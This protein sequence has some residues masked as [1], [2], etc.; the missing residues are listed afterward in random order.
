MGTICVRS[1]DFV[2]MLIPLYPEGTRWESHHAI[3]QWSTMQV[4]GIFVA[5]EYLA[6]RG[7]WLSSGIALR[8]IYPTTM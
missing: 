3:P 8:F 5:V 1:H 6:Q 7:K 2:P 4:L